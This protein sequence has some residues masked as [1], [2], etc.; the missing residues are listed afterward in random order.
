MTVPESA[1]TE[2]EKPVKSVKHMSAA[3]FG[4]Q[5]ISRPIKATNF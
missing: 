3:S 1:Y 4:D 2:I 5:M